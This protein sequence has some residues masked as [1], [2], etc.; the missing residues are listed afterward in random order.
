M[1][2]KKFLFL[3]LISFFSYNIFASET[4]HKLVRPKTHEMEFTCPKCGQRYKG[5]VP[6]CSCEPYNKDVGH[7]GV[8]KLGNWF[9]GF[10]AF[11]KGKLQV[12]A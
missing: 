4:D 11:I 9:N 2:N 3:Y 8:N 10:N 1:N 5:Y 12:V 6:H 7:T